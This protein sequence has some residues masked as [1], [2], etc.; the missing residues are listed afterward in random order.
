[1]GTIPT[2]HH[3]LYMYMEDGG[4]YSVKRPPVF[5]ENGGSCLSTIVL[6]VSLTKKPLAM[7]NVNG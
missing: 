6:T 2:R 5:L 3:F 1:M 7:G 4:T